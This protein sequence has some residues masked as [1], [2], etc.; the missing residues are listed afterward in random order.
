MRSIHD[1]AVYGLGSIVRED[2]PRPTAEAERQRLISKPGS[3][4]RLGVPVCDDLPL[5]AGGLREALSAFSRLL[6]LLLGFMLRPLP[7]VRLPF[8][9]TLR[10]SL[11]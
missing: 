7:L 11:R 3:C 4:T 5:V 10:V 8:P 6:L 1:V 9:I 2:L